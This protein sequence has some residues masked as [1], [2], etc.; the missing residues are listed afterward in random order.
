MRWSFPRRRLHRRPKNTTRPNLRSTGVRDVGDL[1][2]RRWSQAGSQH[3]SLRCQPYPCLLRRRTCLVS[4]GS[5]RSI[6]TLVCLATDISLPDHL[7]IL[8]TGFNQSARATASAASSTPTFLELPSSAEG[9]RK[10]DNERPSVDPEK[11]TVRDGNRALSAA[12]PPD[13]SLSSDVI[14]IAVA[15]SGQLMGVS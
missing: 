8:I 15:V 1:F 12:S 5:G 7:G 10:Q 14:F 6:D 11:Q 4:R 3:R 13:H 2:E 9:M